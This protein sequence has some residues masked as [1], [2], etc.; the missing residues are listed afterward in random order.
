MACAARG[1]NITL[2][3]I[4]ISYRR[5]RCYIVC[6][7][8]NVLRWNI[9]FAGSHASQVIASAK[10]AYRYLRYV[11]RSYTIGKIDDARFIRSVKYLVE[12][13]VGWL[14]L[15]KRAYH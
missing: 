14:R 2:Y 13:H 6:V 9:I 1:L 7:R 10:D 3:V 8:R 12:C 4:E 15:G 5:H 11:P